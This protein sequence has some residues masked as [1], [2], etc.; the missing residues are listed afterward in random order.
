GMNHVLRIVP[1]DVKAQL[2]SYDNPRLPL[3]R[4][5][6][7]RLAGFI[8]ETGTAPASSATQTGR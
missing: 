8:E 7:E 4:L 6:T 5:L 1:L 2:A 3:A